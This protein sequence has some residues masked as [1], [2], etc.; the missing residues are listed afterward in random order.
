[1]G[2]VAQHDLAR[3]R[4]GLQPC[5]EVRRLAEHGDVRTGDG[6]AHD[7]GTDR[8]S[9]PDTEIEERRLAAEGER[10][11]ERVRGVIEPRARCIEGRHDG[12][13][14]EL[15][16]ESVVPADLRRRPPVERAQPVR[17]VRRRARGC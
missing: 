15:V 6:A 16:D 14:C 13:P 1:M 2:F 12:V 11:L 3:G 9:D 4:G 5:G 8:D 7:C 17:D 10:R